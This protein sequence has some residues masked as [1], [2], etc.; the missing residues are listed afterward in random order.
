MQVQYRVHPGQQ[1]QQVLKDHL[2]IM[3]M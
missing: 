3:E 2:V 1:D